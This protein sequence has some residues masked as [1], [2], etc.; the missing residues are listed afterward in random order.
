MKNVLIVDDEEAALVALAEG[1][2]LYLENVKV[3]KA[4]SGVKAL[5]ILRSTHID[6]VVTDL[7]MPIMD[8]FELLSTLNRLYPT[9]PALVMTA[10]S[11]NSTESQLKEIGYSV[12]LEKPLKLSELAARISRILER[13]AAGHL[14]GVTVASF[15][16]IVEMEQ[17]TCTLE[18]SSEGRTGLLYLLEGQLINATCGDKTG[19][20]AAYDLLSWGESEIEIHSGCKYRERSI[21]QNLQYL[22]MEGARRRDEQGAQKKTEALDETAAGPPGEF[23]TA[24]DAEQET[25]ELPDAPLESPTRKMPA[26]HPLSKSPTEAE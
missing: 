20:E 17:K 8:G 12:L 3:F 25:P 1:L 22:L 5:E 4:S 24:S 13:K 18:L 9:I 19:V 21:S 23:L 6:V 26:P 16:Q 10:F 11:T 14:E 7:N 2:G 15:L